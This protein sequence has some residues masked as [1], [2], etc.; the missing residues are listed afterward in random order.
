MSTNKQYG[1]VSL[2]VVIFAMLLL[3]VVTVSFLRIMMTDQRQAS[4]VDLSQSAYDSALAGVEDGKRAILRYQEA[5]ANDPGQCDTYA[6]QLSTDECNTAVRIGG[7]VPGGTGEVLVQQSQSGTDRS[8][9]QA[10]TCVTMDLNTDD[11]TGTIPEGGSKFIPLKGVSSFGQV[12][13]SWFSQEDLTTPTASVSVPAKN[14][15]TPLSLPTKA[16]WPANRPSIL[17]AQLLQYGDQFTLNDFDY[18]TSSSQANAMTL[19]LYPTSNGSVSD[20]FLGRDVRRG[21]TSPNPAADDQSG[22]P[23]PIRCTTSTLTSGGYACN[24]TLSLPQPINNGARTAYLR[25]TS[26]YKGTNFKVQLRTGV[27]NTLVQFKGVQPL[28]DSTGRANDLFR[29]VQSRVELTDTT[30]PY[31]E[32]AVDVTTEFCKDFTVINAAPLIEGTCR[33]N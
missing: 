2:F 3:S 32:A 5:C 26:F 28:I 29:R 33:Y 30:F 23:L 27:W 15:G 7:V 8:L 9:N 13:I 17:R 1:A 11:Y 25:L 31:P 24:A 19:F 22:S 4:D 18:I 21:E 12:Q 20:G 6:T 14:A 10:Y 16:A